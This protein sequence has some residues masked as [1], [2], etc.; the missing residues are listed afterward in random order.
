MAS[1]TSSGFTSP[2]LIFSRLLIVLKPMQLIRSQGEWVERKPF[3][4]K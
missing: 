3:S 2:V 1:I 4:V